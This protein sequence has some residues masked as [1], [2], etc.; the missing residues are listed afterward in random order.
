M[1]TSVGF[2][3]VDVIDAG[4]KFPMLVMYPT[5]APEKDERLGPFSLR[6][7]T[8]VPPL[9][10]TYP[11]VIISHG[12]GGTHVSHRELAR[13]LASKGFVVGVPEHPFNNRND[14][15]LADT[16]EILSERPRNI[17]ATV[18]WFFVRS[19]FSSFL[20]ADSFS[21]VGHSMGGYTALAVAG[22]V[23]TSLPHQTTDR[24]AKRIDVVEDPRLKSIVLLAP[25]TVWFRL[26]GALDRVTAPILMIASYHDE[27]SPYFYM[28]QIV[29]DGVPDA[30]K[31]QYRLVE[32]AVLRGLTAMGFK[33]QQARRALGIIEERWEGLEPP[34][35][36]VLRET[37]SILT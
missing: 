11:L 33:E 12:S 29:M 8:A 25:T 15:T 19:P 9:A 1:L 26:H 22:G 13:H 32:N 18:D 35:E 20:K 3:C 14:N 36:T 27:L 37:L 5:S 17:R 7:A 4:S 28:C 24:Q 6:V 21:I 23:P 31:V 10:G 30:A 2:Q 34:L 16:V